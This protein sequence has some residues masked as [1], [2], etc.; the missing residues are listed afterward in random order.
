MKTITRGQVEAYMTTNFKE[1]NAS[2]WQDITLV[3]LKMAC[4]AYNN[5]DNNIWET[6]LDTYNAKDIS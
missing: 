5:F 3:E 4:L 2:D 1:F 6:I